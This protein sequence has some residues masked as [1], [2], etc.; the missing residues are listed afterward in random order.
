MTNIKILP[1]CAAVAIATGGIVAFSPSAHARQGPVVVTAPQDEEALPTRRVNYADL[2]LASNSGAKRLHWRVNGAIRSV[3]SEGI[4]SG[5][6]F[7]TSKCRDFA[8]DGAQP[9]F[10]RAVQRAREIAMTGKS[11]IAAAAIVLS[12]R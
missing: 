3:C 9:Q 5:D 6:F 12:F 1:L 11:S 2:N 10:D 4:P 7:T 8:W